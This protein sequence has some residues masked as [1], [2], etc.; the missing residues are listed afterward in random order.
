[1]MLARIFRALGCYMGGTTLGRYTLAL[2][3]MLLFWLMNMLTLLPFQ[4]ALL[5]LIFAQG[6]FPLITLFYFTLFWGHATPLWGI[7]VVGIIQDALTGSPFG[8]HAILYIGFYWS[9]STQ[10]R[11]YVQKPYSMLLAGFAFSVF[12]AIVGLYAVEVLF[13]KRMIPL[14]NLMLEGLIVVGLYTHCHL[15]LTALHASLQ[16][17]GEYG[18]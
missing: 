13:F 11:F 1:M 12:M 3:P 15:M 6:L 8:Y 5:Q 7:F 9:V 16:H 10:A 18:Y 14:S 17:E 2:L 4:S